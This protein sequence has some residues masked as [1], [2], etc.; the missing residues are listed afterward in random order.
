MISFVESGPARR[1]IEA[2]P[3]TSVIL[4][5]RM[6]TA[7]HGHAAHPNSARRRAPA[8]WVSAKRCSTGPEERLPGRG[9]GSGSRARVLVLPYSL[10]NDHVVAPRKEHVQWGLCDSMT[11]KDEMRAGPALI[12]E[13][14]PAMLTHH[15]LTGESEISDDHVTEVVEVGQ[16]RGER[17]SSFLAP[18]S[19]HSFSQRRLPSSHHKVRLPRRISRG[20]QKTF[21]GHHR[22]SQDLRTAFITQEN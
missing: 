19:Q 5:L 21:A 8:S 10:V 2:H 18:R 12:S 3:R 14:G 17:P 4:L 22:N 7:C 1:S 16:A 11:A 20:R 6:V 13:V 15:R 9:I